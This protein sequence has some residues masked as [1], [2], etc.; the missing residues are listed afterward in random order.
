ML[1]INVHQLN[2]IFAQTVLLRALKNQVDNIRRVLRFECQ[3]IFVLG[4]AQ[5]LHQGAEVDTEGD[6]SVASE[7]GEGFGFEHHGDQ[8]NVGVV[9]GLQRHAG[10]IAIEVAVL[11]QILDGIDNLRCCISAEA[12]GRDLQPYLLEQVG[13]LQ[14]RFKHCD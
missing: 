8:G 6:V 5:H 2:V 11:D 1:L 13:L 12:M 9:H 7:G 4:A 3:D 14:P 10:V